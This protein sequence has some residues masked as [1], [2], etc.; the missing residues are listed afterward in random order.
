MP[1]V[2]SPWSELIVETKLNWEERNTG[3]GKEYLCRDFPGAWVFRLIPCKGSSWKLSYLYR[4]R[5]YDYI[6]KIHFIMGYF[7]DYRNREVFVCTEEFKRAERQILRDYELPP[8]NKEKVVQ[9]KRWW[10]LF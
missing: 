4:K 9:K 3:F 5:W 1:T 7:Y 2:K 6:I 8:K 10:Q